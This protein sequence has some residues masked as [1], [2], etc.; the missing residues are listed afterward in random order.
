MNAL[1]DQFD[2]Q[3]MDKDGKPYKSNEEL[4]EEAINDLVDTTEYVLSESSDLNIPRWLDEIEDKL[5]IVYNRLQQD[6][7]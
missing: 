3:L 2:I 1:C 4:I 7:D 5:R 6:E